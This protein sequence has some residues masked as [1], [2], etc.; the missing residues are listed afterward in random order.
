MSVDNLAPVASKVAPVCADKVFKN[1]QLVNVFTGDISATDLAVSGGKVIGWGNYYGLEEIDL[2][3]S[4][5]CPGFID[6]HVHLESSLLVPAEFAR[7]VVPLGTT[8]VIADPHEIANV[9]GM[10]GISY[11]LE[12]TSLLPLDVFIMLPSAVPATSLETG[13][14]VLGASDLQSLRSHPRVL[15]LGEVMD[16]NAVL[17]ERPDIM[18]KLNLFRGMVIDG[19]A[20]K[21][22]GT[23]LHRYIALGVGSDHECTEVGEMWEKLS[24]GMHI[25]LRESSACKDLLT[26]LPAVTPLTSR[27]CLLVT[28]D[29]HPVELLKEGHINYLVRLAVANG[30]PPIVAIQMATINT[31]QYFG[32]RQK[33]ALAPG[34]DADF[35]VLDN[36]SDFRPQSVFRRGILVATAGALV[37]EAH[38]HREP[39][40]EQTINVAPLRREQLQLRAEGPLAKVIGLVPNQIM[41]RALE[42]AVPID[43]GCYVADAARDIVKLAVVERH[44]ATGQVGVGLVRGFGLTKG[45]I[46]TSVAHDSHNL[47]VVGTNDAD[48]M[49]AIATIIKLGGGI[50]LVHEGQVL[51]SLALPIAGL[52]SLQSLEE[53]EAELSRLCEIAFALGV[54][55]GTDPFMTLSFLAL[56]VVPELKLTSRGLVDVQSGQIVPC[57]L[58]PAER[59]VGGSMG[60]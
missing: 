34:Y 15:G 31:A 1:V 12:A 39:L 21:L 27:R 58:K 26:L 56:P 48:M 53:V 9:C 25:M 20:P 14:A 29:R 4:Y 30:I 41:T 57:A 37:A 6:G 13:G 3:G 45:A 19:H 36:L 43:D 60:E 23:A 32:L 17:A 11:L 10:A 55:V 28:D 59:R 52:M 24:L 18:D 7:A 5:V 35:L 46:A 40:L 16:C 44:F 22:T 2:A 49:T 8:T 33:G 47:V 38:V 50:A 51:A 42:L 54:R